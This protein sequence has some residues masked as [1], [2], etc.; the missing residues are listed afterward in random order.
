M[1]QMAL[2]FVLVTFGAFVTSLTG[3]GGGTLILAGLLI[4]YP[5]EMALPLHAFTQ[6][7]A[8]AIRTGLY[9][10]HVSWRVVGFYGVLM[11]PAAWG[12][13]QIFEMFNPSW[14]KIVVGVFIL[15][16]IIPF[17]FY[18]KNEPRPRI[19][20]I[21]GAI[22]GFLG[23]FVGAVG[24]MV[25]PFFNRLKLSRDGILS[26][27]SAGQMCLQFSKII[28]FGGAAGINFMAFSNQIGMLILG[29]FLGV[30][31]SIP[32]GKKISD[33]RFNQTVNILLALISVKVIIEGI[34]ELI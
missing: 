14:L 26:T 11:L 31:V 32:V 6:V 15:L 12:A 9:F 13:A 21:L 16:S 8:N 27:K 25:V 22:S 18:P 3:L 29:S 30:L 19:F 28:A 5:P 24:P 10:S 7:T 4:V 17:K 23:I 33:E 2:L 20:M 1:S 34:R